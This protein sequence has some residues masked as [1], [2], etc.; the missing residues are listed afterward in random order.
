MTRT[1]NNYCI[2][3]M[4][5]ELQKKSGNH[6]WDSNDSEFESGEYWDNAIAAMDGVDPRCADAD[7]TQQ[8]L[9]RMELDFQV[10]WEQEKKKVKA[11]L[12][13]MYSPKAYKKAYALVQSYFLAKKALAAL[14]K[15]ASVLKDATHERA[16]TG[17][18]ELKTQDASAYSVE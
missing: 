3:R 7:Q 9:E 14:K 1:G 12:K 11:L 6:P 17:I 13:K 5:T 8:E 15:C 18:A 10:E 4:D 16:P 2:W